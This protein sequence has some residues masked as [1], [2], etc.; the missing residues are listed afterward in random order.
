MNKFVLC[1][2]SSFQ[3]HLCLFLQALNRGIA[4]VKEDRVE[5]LASYGLAYSLMKFFTGP[6]SDFK[7][8][9][10]VLINSKRD[11]L[12][13]VL[14]MGVAGIIA[15]VLH[16]LIGRC[17]SERIMTWLRFC[18]FSPS[19]YVGVFE[20]EMD[21][22]AR[23]LSLGRNRPSDRRKRVCRRHLFMKSG[24]IGLVQALYI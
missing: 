20:T 7:N 19:K 8:V 23:G 11:R 24:S 6:M 12:K 5:M 13:A 17:V 22:K 21:T 9:G 15:F 18:C 4:A 3:W 16:I 2:V 1:G 14:C 10:L